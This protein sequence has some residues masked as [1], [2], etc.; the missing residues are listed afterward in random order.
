MLSAIDSGRCSVLSASSVL[1]AVDSGRCSVLSASSVLSA[2]DSGLSSVL[3]AV[4][5]GRS[6]VTVLTAVNIIFI[7]LILTRCGVKNVMSN[8]KTHRDIKNRIVSN[9]MPCFTLVHT[10]LYYKVP[11]ITFVENQQQNA[12]TQVA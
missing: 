10:P 6:I 11:Y 7:L 8:D 3:S 1:S 2:V 5:R 12:Q 9:P 4:Y